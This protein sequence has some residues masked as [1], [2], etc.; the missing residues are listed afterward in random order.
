M[1]FV[2]ICVCGCVFVYC[3]VWCNCV[4]VFWIDLLHTIENPIQS[5]GHLQI[6][7]GNVCPDG[8]VA[9]LTGKQGTK[10]R[11]IARVFDSEK[12]YML[13]FENGEILNNKEKQENI[14]QVIIIRYEGPKGSPGMPEMLAATSTII[15]TGMELNTAFITDGRFSGYFLFFIYFFL[16]FF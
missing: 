8:S 2:F 5:H 4:C 14:K 1:G 9:K 3:F 11:G 16:C 10:F 6:L 15:G 12:E 7:Y 13:A